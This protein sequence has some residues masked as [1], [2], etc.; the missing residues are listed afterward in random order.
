[1]AGA[2]AT[3]GEGGPRMIQ[4]TRGDEGPVAAEPFPLLALGR[5]A[6]TRGARRRRGAGRHARRP[7]G[8]WRPRRGAPPAAGTR[9]GRV[10]RRLGSRPGRPPRP[11]AADR[12]GATPDPGALRPRRGH[13]RAAAAPGARRRDG[14]SGHRPAGR[15]GG[16]GGGHAAAAAACWATWPSAGARSSPPCRTASAS[17][18]GRWRP[19]TSSSRR[20]APSSRRS[21]SS[22]AGRSWTPTWTASRSRS[23][24]C[25]PRPWRRTG[26][27]CAS[28][29]SCS[30]SGSTAASRTRPASWPATAPSSPARQTLDDVIEQ[31]TERM[32]AMQSLLASMTAAQRAELQSLMDA[33]LRDDRLRWDLAQLASTLDRLLP[34][35]LG[36][37]F[38]FRGDEGLSL[39]GALDQLGRLQRLDRLADEMDAA[40]G[41][42]DLAA[43]DRA[44]V[45]DLL[46]DDAAQRPGG[47]PA[48]DRCPRGGR[49]PGAPRR[50]GRADRAR[51]PPHR[52]GRPRRAVRAAPARRLRLACPARRRG[53]R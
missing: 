51:Q 40:G 50:P 41:P 34:G 20:R 38:A 27:W 39:E 16:R 48:A 5:H 28:S 22:C 10:A 49:L 26:P 37:R 35:G 15:G 46:G 6:A 4:P 29:T 47:P 33:L 2:A 17:G 7:A 32:A 18:S 25:R 11:A 21:W 45:R 44:E 52:A 30:R 23:A 3:A 1:M 36:Q 14:A 19:T 24:T 13:A 9:H 31:L 8:G 43:I 12:R 53:R 42:G